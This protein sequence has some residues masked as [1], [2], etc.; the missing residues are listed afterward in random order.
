MDLQSHS[1]ELSQVLQLIQHLFGIESAV[2]DNSA[3][4]VVSSSK[5]LEKKGT[6]VHKPS[7]LEVLEQDEVTVLNPGNMPF[8]RE[9]SR[10]PGDP[11]ADHPDQLPCRRA[12]LLRLLATGPRQDD[13]GP[14]VL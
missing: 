5:Y 11:E 10:H 6:I 14:G 9:L 7:I 13:P 3:A 1:A 12:V 2:F 8:Q 4:L